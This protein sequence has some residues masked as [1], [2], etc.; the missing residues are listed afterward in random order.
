MVYPLFIINRF[1]EAE[2]ANQANQ[3]G[4]RLAFLKFSGRFRGITNEQCS[5]SRCR[6][7]AKSLCV[8]L[9]FTPRFASF[10]I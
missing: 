3:R 1:V 6:L 8:S 7:F 5:E 2:P 10:F 9:F 4:H